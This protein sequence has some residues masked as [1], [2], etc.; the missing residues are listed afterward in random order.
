MKVFI[1]GQ[2]F[3]GAEG[4][5][6]VNDHGL[7]YGDGVF[8]GIR[9]FAGKPFLLDEHL[10]RMAYGLRAVHL[11]L[12][13]GVP[14]LREAVLTTVAAHAAPDSYVRLIV[15]RGDG[16]LGVDPAGCSTPRVICIVDRIDIFPEEVRRAGISL[17]TVSMRRPAADVLD[18]RVKSLNYLN[19]ALARLESRRQG[20][21][22]ALLLNQ[23]GL[24]A[25][26]SVAN[27][28]VVHGEQLWTPLTTDGALDGVTR[29]VVL[30]LGRQLGLRV[31]ERSL[32][33]TDFFAASEA[34]LTGTG[35]GVVRVRS[36]DGELIGEPGRAQVTERLIDAY[37]T[38]TR[39]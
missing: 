14:R 25:E 35:V 13:G 5:I 27:V 10:Q 24:V 32:S 31:S 30:G 23:H 39:S 17:A 20:A 11:A 21:D 8:E 1:D 16:P 18:P 22:D 36:L 4:R 6:P 33:R 26:A 12:P 19:N 29:A 3:D 7:L 37:D 38:L 34:F 2:L 9:V 28:F 15:T